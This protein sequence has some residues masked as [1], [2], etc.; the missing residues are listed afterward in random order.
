MGEALQ[1]LVNVEWV[2]Q[3][4]FYTYKALRWLTEDAGAKGFDYSCLL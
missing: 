2:N 3:S 1:L 4:S